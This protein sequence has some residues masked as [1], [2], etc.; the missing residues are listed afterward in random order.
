MK[1]TYIFIITVIIAVM[2]ALAACHEN[3]IDETDSSVENKLITV[4]GTL[5]LPLEDTSLYN[6]YNILSIG[7]VAN[8]DDGKFEV[9][10]YLNDKVQTFIVEHNNEIYLMSRTP[11]LNGQSIELSVQS[12]AIAMV[13]MHPLFSPVGRDDYD[14]LTNSIMESPKYQDFYDI[15]AK[16]ISNK[17]HLYDESNEEGDSVPYKN[18]IPTP[19][20]HP[21]DYSYNNRT[22]NMLYQQQQQPQISNVSS[23]YD[24]MQKSKIYIYNVILF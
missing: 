14:A 13:T 8:I 1:R 7:G 17:R 11:L 23:Y 5:N 2:G 20:N 18:K 21:S 22:T 10:A 15:V 9:D 4:E 16:S 24:E 3:I 6:D 19:M 12:T